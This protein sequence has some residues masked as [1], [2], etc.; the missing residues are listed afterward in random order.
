MKLPITYTDEPFVMSA[1][2]TQ[3]PM[4]DTHDSTIER[5]HFSV[6]NA[7]EIKPVTTSDLPCYYISDKS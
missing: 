7:G 5:A 2:Y 4:T 1:L 6:D 3:L